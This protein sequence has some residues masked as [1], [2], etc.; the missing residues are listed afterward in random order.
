MLTDDQNSLLFYHI[1]ISNKLLFFINLACVQSYG[2]QCLHPC[3]LHCYNKTCDRF[4]G[5]CLLGCKD[6]FYGELCD[7][8][9]EDPGSLIL[10]LFIVFFKHCILFR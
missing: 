10:S 6:G 1:Y 2:E 5:R 9:N 4:N 8:G 3:S 7:R